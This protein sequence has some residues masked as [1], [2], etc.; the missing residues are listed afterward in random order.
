MHAMICWGFIILTIATTVVMLDYDFRIPLMRGYF[1]L[2][3]QSFL[4]DVFGALVIVGIGMAA[5]RRWVARPRTLVYTR[6]ASAILCVIA[7]ILFSGFLVE[8]WRI[9]ATD[10]PW[11]AWSPVG[12]LFARASG[13]L[14]SVEAM[15]TAHATTWWTHLL[16][17]FGFLAWA[18]YTKLA[19][20][21]TSTLNIYTA[22]L[23]PI[24]GAN[25]AKVDSESEEPLGIHSARRLHLEGSVGFRRLHGMRPLHGRLP[26]QSRRQTALAARHHS[27]PPTVIA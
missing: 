13:R 14:M 6:E 15:R 19:H 3:F 1:Y 10:D 21:V 5:V 24:V 7:A 2:V 27:G 4:T 8:G 23:A 20:V 17:A 12:Y 9:A 11:G 18:P 22:R 25:C 16:L 26:C